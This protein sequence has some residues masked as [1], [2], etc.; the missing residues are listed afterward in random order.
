MFHLRSALRGIRAMTPE[1][2]ASSVSVAVRLEPYGAWGVHLWTPMWHEG[3]GP[4]VSIRLWRLALY[5]G[6]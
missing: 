3:R 6:Y 2:D 1:R 5:R 4:Y